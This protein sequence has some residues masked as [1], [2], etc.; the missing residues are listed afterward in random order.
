[1]V[2]MVL[3]DDL[4][5]RAERDYPEIAALSLIAIKH[6]HVWWLGEVAHKRTNRDFYGW[7]RDVLGTW[8]HRDPVEVWARRQEHLERGRASA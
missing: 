6:L 4:Q 7:A 5:R 8:E 3:Y 1:M 2:D